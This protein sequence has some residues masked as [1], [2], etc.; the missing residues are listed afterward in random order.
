MA[1]GSSLDAELRT[2][3]AAADQ[4]LVGDAE[5]LAD[6]ESAGQL[7]RDAVARGSGAA[8]SR[9]A[10]MAAVGVGRPPDWNEAL[11]R[12][13]EGALLGDRNARRQLAVLAQAS[14]ARIISGEAESS[15]VWQR[16]RS[17]L[18]TEALLV[19]APVE[20]VSNQPKI[21]FIREFAS[22][23]VCRWLIRRS[24][25]LLAPGQVND[26]QTG[27]P[28]AHTMRTA[29]SAAFTV[30]NRDV[31]VALMQAR[32]ER[33]TG[34]RVAQHEPPNVIKYEPGQEFSEHFD[35]IDPLSPH[36]RNELELLG[37]RVVT[38]VTY[39]NDGFKGA[40]TAFPAA[41]LKLRGGVGDCILFVNVQPDGQPDRQTL[42]AGLP[43]VAGR[44][45]ILS[46]WLRNRPQPLL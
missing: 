35:F 16:L 20:W 26:A 39:L 19:P 15:A 33:A 27:L 28:R 41:G 38:C 10:M 12:L 45:W 6:P 24:G 36:F 43:P 44:K 34:L 7:Y 11:D 22:P 9:L 4:L 18:N 32:A 8:A 25:D 23:A 37:Q 17:G 29:M 5:V 1:S 31:V 21:G 30:L 42:H 46:Q 13:L 14:E 3:L 40:E 2:A